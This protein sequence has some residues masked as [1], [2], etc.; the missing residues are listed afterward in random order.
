LSEQPFHEEELVN[1]NVSSQT[2]GAWFLRLLGIAGVAVAAIDP[3][4]LPNSYRNTLTVVS[5]ILLAVDRYLTDPST[6]N[7]PTTPPSPPTV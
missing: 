3:S 6:G 2:L 7:P 1:V 4:N 5:A